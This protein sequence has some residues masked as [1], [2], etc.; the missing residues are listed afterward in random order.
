MPGM[1]DDGGQECRWQRQIGTEGEAG[2]E[3]DQGKAGAGTALQT[4][5][6]DE[7]GR[8]QQHGGKPGARFADFQRQPHPQRHGAGG[9]EEVD[10]Q[11]QPGKLG[12][13]Q[14]VGSEEQEQGSRY[15]RCNAIDQ[16]DQEQVPKA[17]LAQRQPQRRERK[18]RDG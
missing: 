2:E 6:P 16:Q 5:G 12:Q 17:R 1:V 14:V 4:K 13:V 15:G 11:K 9:G 8:G 18:A 10:Q 3:A 7:D